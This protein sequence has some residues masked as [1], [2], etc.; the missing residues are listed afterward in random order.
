MPTKTWCKTQA[1]RLGI[2]SIQRLKAGGS[3][4]SVIACFHYC[5]VQLNI[6]EEL[7][8]IIVFENS[9]GLAR[10]EVQTD[11]DT[12]WLT[13]RQL[14][15]LFNKNIRTINEHILNIFKEGEA[16][17]DATVRNFRIVRLEGER[18]VER[19]VKHYNLDITISVGYR[20]KSQRGVEFRRWAT[21]VLKQ[22]L[23]DGYTLNPTRLGKA[24]GSLLDLFKM[25]VQLW[26]RQELLNNEL[27][28]DI[29]QLGEKIQ[30]IEAK[31]KSVDDNYYTIAGYCS[32]HKIACPFH[33]AK[34]WGKTATRLSREQGITTGTAHDERF[35]LVRTY[36]Q[37]ILKIAI[38]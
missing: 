38:K 17:E 33:K 21:G 11:Y 18:Q 26:E 37:D 19:E 3:G 7:N 13:Q 20:V 25:Q 2:C 5:P 6:M 32:L 10:L 30:H 24:P 14:A 16:D 34:G 8:E 27:Q 28:Q 12:V 4:S 9:D 29:Q 22:Y 36:H 15:E 35:G 31:V 23:I 1:T